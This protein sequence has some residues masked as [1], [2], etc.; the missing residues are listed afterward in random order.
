MLLCGWDFP[1][2]EIKVNDHRP[3][4]PIIP[5]FSINS[6]NWN[7][8]LEKLQLDWLVTNFL[9]EKYMPKINKPKS[10]K[11]KLLNTLN[12]NQFLASWSSDFLF[13]ALSLEN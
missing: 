12:M 9:Q 3:D 5:H 7:I 11:P 6:D 13:G 8:S 10:I 4:A 2:L 1:Y